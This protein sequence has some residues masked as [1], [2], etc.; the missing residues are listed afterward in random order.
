MLENL[1]THVSTPKHFTHCDIIPAGGYIMAKPKYSI[2]IEINSSLSN[3]DESI[4]RSDLVR[5]EL[6]Q[7]NKP[8]LQRDV[9]LHLLVE[10]VGQILAEALKSSEG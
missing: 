3:E 2:R 9:P 6:F 10:S 4:H 1:S 5:V 7:D 8:V